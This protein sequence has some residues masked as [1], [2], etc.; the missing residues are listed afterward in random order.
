MGEGKEGRNSN[1]FYWEKENGD[2]LIKYDG[3]LNP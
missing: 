1:G 3:S 2:Y